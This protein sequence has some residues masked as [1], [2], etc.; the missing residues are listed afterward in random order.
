MRLKIR[1]GIYRIL[2]LPI[3]CCFRASLLI[4][5]EKPIRIHVRQSNRRW[6]FHRIRSSD[7]E[8]WSRF[9][10]DYSSDTCSCLSSFDDTCFR[11]ESKSNFFFCERDSLLGLL[12]LKTF[13]NLL[14]VRLLWGSCSLCNCR[15][16]IQLS[17]CEKKKI[18]LLFSKWINW[19]A[20]EVNK[21]MIL[22]IF[23]FVLLF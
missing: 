7:G 19:M 22:D 16:L 6:F 20:I 14:P 15:C 21:W 12:G 8:G 3:R 13:C 10:F 18:R 1:S 23:Y 9:A 17:S 5:G 11:I 4:T 2:S